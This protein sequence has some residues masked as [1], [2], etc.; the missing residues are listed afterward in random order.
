MSSLW[1]SLLATVA[2]ADLRAVAFEEDEV[3]PAQVVRVVALAGNAGG[4]PD[5]AE[6]TFCMW[7]LVFVVAGSRLGAVLEATPGGTLAVGELPGGAVLVG[8]VA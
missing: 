5:V 1:T 2:A 7:H 3:P 4:F 8:F 6:V